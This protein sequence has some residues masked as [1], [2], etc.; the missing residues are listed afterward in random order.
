M[1]GGGPFDPP[2][3]L[4]CSRVNYQN[5][6]T[7]SSFSMTI[8]LYVFSINPGFVLIFNNPLLNSVSHRRT[9]NRQQVME[10]VAIPRSGLPDKYDE[11]GGVG[12]VPKV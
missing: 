9:H 2:A 7:G 11:G 10:Y 3:T 8:H 6:N 4:G 12:G 5:L 1:G